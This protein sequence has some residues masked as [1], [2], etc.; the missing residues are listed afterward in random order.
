[1]IETDTSD[2]A[3]SRILN[4]LEDDGKWHLC[5]FMSKSFIPAQVNYDVHDK[6]MLAIVRAFQEW[7]HLLIGSPQTITVYTDHANL[8]YFNTTKVLN[9]RQCRWS[10]YLSQFDFKIIYRPGNLNGKADALSH[11]TDP[12][13]ERGSGEMR[14][15][16]PGELVPLGEN[17]KLL[18]TKKIAAI[19]AREQ[20]LSSSW[21]RELK[22]AAKEDL[23]YQKRLKRATGESIIC[24]STGVCCCEDY[25]VSCKGLLLMKRKVYIPNDVRWQIKVVRDH[26]DTKVAGHFSWDKTYEMI[27]HKFWFPCLEAFMRKYVSSCDVCQRNKSRRHRP[28]G[29]L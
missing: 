23:E 7:E 16:K 6:E 18:D 8:Q 27:K 28:Y 24:P 14:F 4:Q 20:P 9:R 13:L 11:R 2:L 10:D 5:A 29:E 21:V 19:L 22:D 12:A 25:T 3:M 17:E 15:F 1:M 26:H